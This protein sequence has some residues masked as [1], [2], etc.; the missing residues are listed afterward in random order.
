M[1]EER[2]KRFTL[3]LDVAFQRRLKAIAA[4]KDV[5]MR[6]YCMSAIEKEIARDEAEG[7]PK[8]PFNEEYLNSLVALQE[9]I[10]G[11]RELLGDSAD[12]IREAREERTKSQ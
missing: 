6:Q 11:D 9:E 8:T 10:F 2:K 7:L 4:L 1:M 12:F 3:D 5:S